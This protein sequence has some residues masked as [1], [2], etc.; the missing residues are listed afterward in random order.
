MSFITFFYGWWVS[1]LLTNKVFLISDVS[2][3][4]SGVG[5]CRDPL[6]R[7]GEVSLF[8]RFPS[9]SPL[10]ELQN[11]EQ[12]NSAIQ[13]DI[14]SLKRELDYYT[15]VLERHK[16]FCCLKEA[17][18]AS[19]STA[20]GHSGSP[21][22]IT[23]ASA[24]AHTAELSIP[25]HH[26]H[27]SACLSSSTSAAAYDLC[28]STSTFTTFAH[29]DSFNPVLA[30]H[31]LFL[32]D[33]PPLTTQEG[34]TSARTLP[35]TAAATSP[36]SRVALRNHPLPDLFPATASKSTF[37][38]NQ[39]SANTPLSCSH[40]SAD[41]R[42]AVGSPVSAHQPVHLKHLQPM[43]NTLHLGLP[44]SDL[45]PSPQSLSEAS[46]FNTSF[47]GGYG[48][49]INSESESLLSLLTAPPPISLPQNDFS[50]F[51]ESFA[52]SS[53]SPPFDISADL[54]LSELLSTDE[55]ILE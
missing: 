51:P 19:A 28:S 7:N 23:Q 1:T 35:V 25:S 21:T 49:N 36:P 45:S 54:S 10:Q 50:N 12:L 17:A 38:M 18:V 9:F 2:N 43:E 33:S 20:D 53:F 11:L 41:N 52:Q 48:H 24:S 39:A 4:P 6:G 44:S 14:D 3:I 47:G 30:S 27:Q 34:A 13:K 22:A 26:I 16:P 37:P 42:G 55:W 40:S 8:W 46:A 32:G 5:P 29:S 31:S 15:L